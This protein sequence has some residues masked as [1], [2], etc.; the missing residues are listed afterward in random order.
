MTRFLLLLLAA[1]ALAT[2]GAADNKG[3]A[4]AWGQCG[5]KTHEGPTCCAGDGYGCAY[6]SEYFSQCVPGDADELAACQP[7]YYQCGGRDWKGPRC[8]AEGGTCVGQD[9]FY[10]QCKPPPSPPPPPP[11]PPPSTSAVEPDARV[12]KSTKSNGGEQFRKVCIFDFDDTIKVNS[13]GYTPKGAKRV[14][15]ARDALGII[16]RCRSMGFGVAI[17]TAS[18]S[19]DFVRTFLEE[20]VDGGIFS[21]AML[22]SPRYQSCQPYKTPAL[23]K[24]LAEYELSATPECAVLFDDKDFNGKFAAEAGVSFEKVDGRTGVTWDDF[25]RG[26]ALL[27]RRCDYA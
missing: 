20:K 3:C 25:W 2:R 23:R 1:A 8:C 6:Q 22:D 16:R 21:Q 27:D 14:V 9:Q 15:R 7:F 17:A 5:G 24:I 4:P 12:A 11:P 19:E 13:S 10:S 26:M 18:C